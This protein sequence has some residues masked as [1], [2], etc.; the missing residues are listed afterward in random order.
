MPVANATPRP[1]S[2]LLPA[3]VALVVVP[4]VVGVLP[5][6]CAAAPLSPVA[7]VSY[8]GSDAAPIAV[9]QDIEFVFD[10]NVSLT[11]AG[12]ASDSSSSSSAG[13]SIVVASDGSDARHVSADTDVTL[14]QLRVDGD[15]LILNLEHDLLPLTTYNV[16]LEHGIV[17]DSNLTPFEGAT[18]QVTTGRVLYA[19][20]IR[21]DASTSG[22]GT[23]ASPFESI[24]HATR[25]AQPADTVYVLF[26]PDDVHS[27]RYILLP[28]GTEA[29]P[30]FVKPAPELQGGQQPYRFVGATT[31]ML[32][33]AEH[34][35]IEGFVFD[36]NCADA[37]H[38]EVL[39][40][41]VWDPEPSKALFGGIAVNIDSGTFVRVRHNVF[42]HLQQKA[43][44]IR[45]GRYVAVEENIICNVA[46][47]SLSGGHAI[48]RQQRSGTFG[49]P[50][51]ADVLRWA[52]RGN[53]LFNVQQRVYSWVR[54]K[55]YLNMV[56]DEGKP[57]TIDETDDTEFAGRISD[58]VVAYRCALVCM[59]VC[60]CVCMCV[61]V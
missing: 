4:L 59:C 26:N 18:L 50:D 48:M 49:T 53:M 10:R 11:A 3:L 34:A 55:G 39:A 38:W 8:T 25:Q 36:G 6:R 41:Y 7:L 16:S 47:V 58:N 22:G 37:D 17:Q 60:I 57:I 9:A 15:R 40:K 33:G 14:L 29:A 35:V 28:A 5:G 30:V 52:I 46:F 21:G 54:T 2:R 44:N 56:L 32:Q 51:L 12:T 19:A 13:V 20:P 43:V 24:G 45:D 61:C 1:L 31:F 42:Q 23:L 27:K